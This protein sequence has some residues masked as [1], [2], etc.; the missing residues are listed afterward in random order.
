MTMAAELN[1]AGTIARADLM[2]DYSG[3]EIGGK[4][5]ICPVRSVALSR[6]RMLQ[7]LTSDTMPLNAFLGPFQTRLND[8]VFKDYHLFRAEMRIL[9]DDAAQPP[10]PQR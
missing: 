6:V 8:V 7:R 2:V 5:Y 4:T 3:V 1:H 10:T 9:T